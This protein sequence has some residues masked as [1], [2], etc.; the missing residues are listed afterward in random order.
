MV[1]IMRGLLSTDVKDIKVVS[2]GGCCQVC[3]AV[4]V[5]KAVTGV[6]VLIQPASLCQLQLTMQHRYGVYSSY[7]QAVT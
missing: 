4:G 3:F 6:L 1:W 2:T 7:W 5:S